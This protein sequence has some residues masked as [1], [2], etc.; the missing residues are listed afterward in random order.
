[1]SKVVVHVDPDLSDL[2]PGF[3]ERKRIDLA[4][5]VRATDAGDYDALA[6]IGHKIKGEGG[7]YGFEVITEIGA[8]LEAAA[9]AHDLSA[10]RQ[11]AQ[12]FTAF[13]DNVEVV[14]D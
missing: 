8:A 1:L 4:E 12:D 14:Y 7:S 9:A 13:L 10:L 3:L 5:I 2:I 11:R 6:R